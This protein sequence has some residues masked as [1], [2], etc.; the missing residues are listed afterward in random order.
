VLFNNNVTDVTDIYL[1]H[2]NDYIVWDFL[3]QTSCLF[4]MEDNIGTQ[5]RWLW[6]IFI[7]IKN[8]NYLMLV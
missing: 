3:H 7:I 1:E 5:I 4:L 2:W 8:T 6:R